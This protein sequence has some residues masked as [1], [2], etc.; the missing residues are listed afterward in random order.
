[1]QI[2][3]AGKVREKKLASNKA[4]LPLFEALVNSIH[5]IEELQSDSPGLIEVEVE[6]L[7]QGNLGTESNDDQLERKSPIIAFKVIDNGIGFNPANWE[8]FN[9]AHSSYKYNKGGKGIGRIT[10]LRAFGSVHIDSIYRENGHFN[11]RQFEF[12]VSKNGVENPVNLKVEDP[13]LRRRTIVY[14]KNLNER[15]QQWTN[16]DLED[17]AIKIIEHCFSFFREP[18]CPRILLKDKSDEIVVNDYFRN[19]TRNSLDKKSAKIK[20]TKFDFEV[21]KMYSSKPDNKIH[22]RAHRREVMNDKLTDFIP[23]LKQQLIDKDGEKF[24]LAVYV[25]S[26]YLDD[27]V[28]EERTEISFS[29]A[30]EFFP[31]E[32]EKVEVSEKAVSIVRGLYQ[33]YIEVIEQERLKNIRKFVKR[34]PRYRYLEKYKLS[35]LKKISSNLSGKKLEIE[36]FKIQNQLERDVKREANKMLDGIKE[37]DHKAAFDE[38]HTDL[39][40]KI[41]EVGNSK[42]AEYVVHRSYILEHLNKHLKKSKSG[43]YSKEEIIHNLIFPVR[44][45]SDEIQLEEHNLWVIDERLAFHDYLASDKPLTSIERTESNSLKRPDLVVFNKAHLLNESDNYSSIVIVEFKKP[46]R[47]DYNESDNPITQVLNYVIE[48][49]ENNALDSS[50]RP[51]SVRKGVPFYAYIISDLTPKLRTLALKASFTA[52]PDN[53]G[54]F[55]YN[56]NYELYIEIISFDKM[57]KDSK[58]RNQILFEKLNLPTT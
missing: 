54:F 6:R 18:D 29:K 33:E 4:L 43:K 52:H 23:E 45:T 27:K 9:F 16:S 37:I 28:N 57:V 2:D 1:M 50:G 36:L 35:E 34:H 38:T 7:Q 51:I 58:K 49:Q 53:Q 22:Y 10:W 56:S 11:Q 39:Y 31:D 14:L 25:S 20:G 8:S 5:A 44:K 17:I 12:K 30:D 21:V 48:I 41:I 32:I 42:L 26:D 13:N 3:I 46:M 47:D 55:T 24:S 19:Y 15:F 40:N